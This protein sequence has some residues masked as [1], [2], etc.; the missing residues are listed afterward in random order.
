LSKE[1]KIMRKQLKYPKNL[2]R[3]IALLFLSLVLAACSRSASTPPPQEPVEKVVIQTVEV[4]RIIEPPTPTPGSPTDPPPPT[5]A[6]I[7]IF[8]DMELDDY[9]YAGREWAYSQ[10]YIPGCV[11]VDMTDTSKVYSCH[12]DPVPRI[13][14]VIS[15]TLWAHKDGDF[16]PPAPTYRAFEDPEFDSPSMAELVETYF[17]M[18]TEQ[19]A[20]EQESAVEPT[21]TP[22]PTIGPEAFAEESSRL[23]LLP[24]WFLEL[25]PDLHFIDPLGEATEC[26]AHILVQ[27]SLHGPEV[28]AS[29][30]EY[31]APEKRALVYKPATDRICIG[32][33]EASVE[34][35]VFLRGTLREVNPEVDTITWGYW[36]ELLFR[37]EARRILLE[38]TPTPTSSATSSP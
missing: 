7:S 29:L 17:T 19:P 21:P 38:A 12:D 8:S 31:I 36:S 23:H 28:K 2:K 13:G 30:E 25:P 16:R 5:A 10:G 15:G 1:D 20:E 32:A 14:L 18:P 27:Y 3:F 6:P 37:A 24:D 4:T 33:M 11:I 22:I 9:G 35:K 26:D 34:E